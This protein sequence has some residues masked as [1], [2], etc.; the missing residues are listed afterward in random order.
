MHVRHK[1]RPDYCE[2][3][4]SSSS[5]LAEQ[6]TLNKE[7]RFHLAKVVKLRSEIIQKYKSNKN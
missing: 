5:D 7:S 2:N 4:Y 6:L 3:L 1:Y